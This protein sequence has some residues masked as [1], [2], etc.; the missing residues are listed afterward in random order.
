MGNFHQTIE[1]QV[2]KEFLEAIQ[3]TSHYHNHRTSGPHPA[4]PDHVLRQPPSPGHRQA[5]VNIVCHRKQRRRDD[6]DLRSRKGQS[7]A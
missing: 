1:N 2:K 5:A 4:A 7:R 3:G 6:D